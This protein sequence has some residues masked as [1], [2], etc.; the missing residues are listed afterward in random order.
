MRKK[1]LLII[2]ASIACYKSLELIRLLRK[3]DYEVEVVL[4]KETEKFITPLLVSSI[5]GKEVRQDLFK[6]DD[7]DSMDHIN[8]SR[9]NDLIVVAPASANFIAKISNGITDDLASAIILAADKKIFLAPA[10]NVKMWQNQITQNNLSKLINSDMQIIG[11]DKDILACGEFGFG[12]MTDINN[13]FQ[14]IE[15]F[16][17]NSQKFTGKK[18]IVTAGATFEPID[19]VRFIGNY[20]SGKQGIFIAEILHQMGGDVILI[21]SNIKEDINLPEK[22]IIRVSSSN[23]ILEAIEEN[24]EDSDIYISAAA[25]SDF[26]PKNYSDKKIKKGQNVKNIELELNIDI[27]EI[28]GHSKNRPKIVIGFAAESNDLVENAIGKANRKNCDLIIANDVKSGK[29][30]GANDNEITIVDKNK[31]ITKIGKNSKKDIA[32]EIVKWIKI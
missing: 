7:K 32:K 17:I 28:I 18:I 24:I 11:P 4:T 3:D 31:I 1:I 21:A 5:L 29:V 27:L 19:P 23:Q 10:M 6:P 16:F 14:G 8:L 30:F 12:K 20:S 9:D 22:N 25:I 26:K 15:D 13:I 2:T